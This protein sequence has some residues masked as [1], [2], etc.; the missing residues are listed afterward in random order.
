M[1]V[2]PH[3]R[4]P[5]LPLTA[6]GII[7]HYVDDIYTSQTTQHLAMSPSTSLVVR[8]LRVYPVCLKQPL[9]LDS[10]AC[11]G[12]NCYFVY[13]ISV[14]CCSVYPTVTQGLSEIVIEYKLEIFLC[15]LVL[16]Y[17]LKL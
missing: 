8:I 12:L 1:Q 2:W 5:T 15:Q 13:S 9:F 7:L 3:K 4:Y 16:V 10:Y 14:G 11:D 17:K 6:I